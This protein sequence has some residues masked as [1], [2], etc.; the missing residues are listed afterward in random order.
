MRRRVLLGVENF[1]T[2]TQQ[3]SVSRR[4]RTWYITGMACVEYERGALGS[5]RSR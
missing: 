4:P 3:K 5:D 2:C 1:T